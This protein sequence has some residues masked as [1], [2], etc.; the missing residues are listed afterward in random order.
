[1]GFPLQRTGERNLEGAEVDEVDITVAI[2]VE[3]S[4]FTDV[5]DDEGICS[6]VI[7]PVA[8]EDCAVPCSQAEDIG[9][10]IESAS[11]PYTEQSA[12]SR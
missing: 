2:A 8:V 7:I 11:V 1:M 6:M 12:Y 3:S 4:A 10:V 5:D 9:A